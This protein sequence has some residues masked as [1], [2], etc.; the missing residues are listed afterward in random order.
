MSTLMHS[1]KIVLSQSTIQES[2]LH[3]T[4]DNSPLTVAQPQTVAFHQKNILTAD[5]AAALVNAVLV[6]GI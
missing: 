6:T 5:T 2:N 3:L 1:V 4:S